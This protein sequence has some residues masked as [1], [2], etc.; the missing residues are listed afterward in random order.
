ME[1]ESRVENRKISMVNLAETPSCRA[2]AAVLAPVTQL[3]GDPA[4]PQ[5][6][7]RVRYPR[8]QLAQ[9]NSKLSCSPRLDWTLPDL[10]CRVLFNIHVGAVDA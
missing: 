6:T 10:N 1:I 3:A 9:S 7:L 8:P 4:R 5:I 2:R